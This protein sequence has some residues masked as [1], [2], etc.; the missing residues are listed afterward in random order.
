MKKK[1]FQVS[2]SHQVLSDNE[3]ID[4]MLIKHPPSAGP[5]QVLSAHARKI[6]TAKWGY[7]ALTL[8]NEICLLIA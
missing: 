3:F 6:P 4:Q 2:F 1:H 7:V 5:G 8:K